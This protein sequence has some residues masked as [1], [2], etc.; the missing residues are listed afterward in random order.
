MAGTPHSHN[1]DILERLNLDL[2]EDELKKRW[3]YKDLWFR[4]QN[5]TW[6]LQSNFIYDTFYFENLLECIST[7]VQKNQFPKRAFFYYAVNRWYNYWS[8]RGI[9]QLFCNLKGV[10]PAKHTKD[11]LVDFSI[12]GINFDHKTSIFPK[13]FNYN[14][15]YA[16]Q[17]P[18]QLIYWLYNNQST[19]RR[20]HTE[21]RLFIIVYNHEGDHYKLKAEISWLGRLIENYVSTFEATQLKKITITETKTVFSDIIWAIQ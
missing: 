5:N 8:A 18:I 15:A 17:N 6:D 7:A 16:Q 2:L 9:E 14:F 13:K 20:F 10:T 4:K 21:N 3:P 19:G 11:R 1:H 12:N